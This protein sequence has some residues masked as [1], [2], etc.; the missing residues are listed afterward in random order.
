MD[1]SALTQMPLAKLDYQPTQLFLSVGLVLIDG[2]GML[3]C[4]NYYSCLGCAQEASWTHNKPING[5]IRVITTSY[6]IY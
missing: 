5:E 3:E 2:V 1:H 6:S 4:Y